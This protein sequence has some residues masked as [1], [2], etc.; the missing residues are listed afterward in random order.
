MESQEIPQPEI[1]NQ[2]LDQIYRLGAIR[3]AL[4]LQLWDK[5]AI[6]EDTPVKLAAAERWDPI[7]AQA[8]LNAMCG[9][10]LMK[11]DKGQYSLVP[12]SSCYLVPSN[13]AYQVIMIQNE[14][15]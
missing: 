15:G 7:G 14:M 13:P 12:E 4:E 5:V 9:M 1:I 8:L 6:G 11:N 10:G 2:I 3:A